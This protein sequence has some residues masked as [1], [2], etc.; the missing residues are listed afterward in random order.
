MA[1]GEFPRGVSHDDAIRPGGFCRS[2]RR[3]GVGVDDDDSR[4]RRAA[5]RH[6]GGAGEARSRRW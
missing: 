3:D 1:G 4:R 6:P 2:C 5:D